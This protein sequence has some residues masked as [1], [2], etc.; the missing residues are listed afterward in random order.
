MT[1]RMP[2]L[3]GPGATLTPRATPGGAAHPAWLDTL[4]TRA[5]T[6]EASWFS[7][8]VPPDEGG[9]ESAVLL[10]FGPDPEG[11]ESVLLIERS[12]D[13]R[14]HPGQVALPGGAADAEDA[15]VV[16]T[17][18]REAREEVNLDP[19]GV[20]VLGSLPPLFLP[21]SGFVVTTVVGWW[22]EPSPISVG[23]PAEVAQVVLAPLDYLIDP[24]TRHTVSHPSGYRGPAFRLAD[25]LLLWGFTGGIVTKALELGGLEQPWDASVTEPLPQRFLGGRS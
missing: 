10:L 1:A 4:M 6:T 16:A 14:S 8:F 11:A 20:E 25:D 18:L 22:R 24:A 12:H 15:D 19:S 13:M 23:D 7:R 17:A 5:A 3:A 2:S 9:R 21:P